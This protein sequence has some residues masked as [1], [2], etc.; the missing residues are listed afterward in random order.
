MVRVTGGIGGNVV[1]VSRSFVF[2][3]EKSAKYVLACIYNERQF[4]GFP[5][6]SKLNVII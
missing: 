2:I 3:F 5:K 4:L 1:R 6:A